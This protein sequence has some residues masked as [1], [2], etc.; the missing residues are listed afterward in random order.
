MRMCEKKNIAHC[1]PSYN[2]RGPTMNKKNRRNY[3]PCF[4]YRRNYIQYFVKHGVHV[5]AL[6]KKIMS[7]IS[8]EDTKQI[9][10]GTQ[11]TM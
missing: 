8:S 3:T 1:T 6:V 9:T 7:F 4:T 10:Y 11:Q 5:V 2:V